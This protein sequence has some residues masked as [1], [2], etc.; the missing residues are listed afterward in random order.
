MTDQAKECAEY[1][2]QVPGFR[3][4]MEQLLIRYRR[5][6]CAAGTIRLDNASEQERDAL[7]GLFGYPF[8]SEVK[9]KVRDFYAAL[10]SS[11]FEGVDLKDVLEIYFHTT[12]HRA[13]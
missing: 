1:F 8:L 5:N 7:C 11:R 2:R 12:I 3:R 10:Q 4:V 9:F 13:C 6:G